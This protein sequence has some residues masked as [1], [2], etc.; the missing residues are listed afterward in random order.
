MSAE[1]LRYLVGLGAVALVIAWVARKPAELAT[2][3]LVQGLAGRKLLPQCIDLSCGRF[4]R[5]GRI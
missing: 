5:G 1:S 3:V 4:G 2:T